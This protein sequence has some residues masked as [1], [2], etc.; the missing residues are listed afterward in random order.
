MSNTIAIQLASDFLQKFPRTAAESFDNI[1]IKNQLEVSEHISPSQVARLLV[2][3]S[4][5]SSINILLN[6]KQLDAILKQM[7]PADVARIL[8]R[9]DK[10]SKEEVMSQASE[11][12]RKEIEQILEYP[13]D[14]AGALME[15]E[16][17]LFHPDDLVK[18]AVEKIRKRRGKNVS[19]VFLVDHDGVLQGRV[20]LQE[21]IAADDHTRLSEIAKKTPWVNE[22]TPREE[23]AETVENNAVPSLPVLNGQNIVLGVIR[24]EKLIAIAQKDA[25]DG[26]QTMVGVS[27]DEKALSSPIFSVKKR[28]PWLSINLITTFVAAFVV[29]L[30]EDTIAKITALAILLPVV[31][32]QSGNTGAQAQAVTMRGLALREIRLRHKWKVL[33]KEGRVGL[34]NGVIVGLLCSV[35]VFFWS[36]SLPLAGVIGVSMVLAMIAAS[37]S[38]AAIPMILIA[39]NQDPATSSSIILTTVTDIVGFLSFLGLATIFLSYLT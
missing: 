15:T 22:L 6:S 24:H 30:F 34:Y 5:E 36:Q 8:S 19:S 14:T 39:M 12:L 26:L 4:P 27:K 21:L 29:G 7:D 13:P 31:A 28:L 11:L 17:H 16:I 35:S 1:D 23:V 32:G 38:G 10:S 37:L 20:Y 9:A 3:I 2:K 18:E 33:F 25:L